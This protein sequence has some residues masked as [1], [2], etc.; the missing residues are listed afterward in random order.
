MVMVYTVIL[1]YQ[2]IPMIHL[3]AREP[4]YTVINN[5]ND[6]KLSESI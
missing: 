4:L 5:G 3:C 1:L 6:E 2:L